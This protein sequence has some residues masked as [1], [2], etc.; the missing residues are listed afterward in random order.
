MKTT[1][2]GFR[3]ILADDIQKFIAHKRVLGRRFDVEEKTLRLFDRYI[4]DQ[5][6]S[7]LRQISPDLI[8]A[9]LAS[10][11]RSR[12]RSY[13][14]LLGTLRRFF[15]W[16]LKLGT[17][18]RSPILAKPRRQTSQRIPY[19]FDLP[20][21]RRLLELAQ[22]LPDNGRAPM[23][24]RTYHAIFAILYGL[25]L[26]VGEVCRLQVKDVDF[27]RLLLVIRK[28]K[29]GKDRLVPFGPRMEGLLRKHLQTK[30]HYSTHS[31]DAPVFSF[32][33][34]GEIHPGTVSQTFHK[35]VPR[36][37]LQIP[38]G[39]SPPRLHD[40]RHSF[41]VGT[42][43]R[44]YR[45]GNVPGTGLLKLATF[46]GHVDANSTAVYLTISDTLLREANRRFEAF[47]GPMHIEVPYQ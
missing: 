46:L 45:N 29:F 6:V 27:D 43:L 34:R 39:C 17:L 1:W 5:Q 37:R 20:T 4:A 13:N 14:H 3:S 44:W 23:R 16:L 11:P 10:R 42:L 9:F 33:I 21:A 26:R 28:T 47:T 25:G 7:Q 40:L 24:G 32:T 36:L 30:S 2:K 31:P 12:P 15:N 8:E 18:D 35:L 41:A 19:I 22:H 38:S